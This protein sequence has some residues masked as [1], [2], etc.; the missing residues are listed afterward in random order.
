MNKILL[1]KI[2]IITAAA[3]FYIS[4]LLLATKRRKP[5]LIFGILASALNFG[6][7]GYNFFVN[8]YVPFVSMYQVLTF[9]ALSF[10]L[11]YLYLHFSLKMKWLAPYFT[12][13]SALVLTGV[14]FMPINIVWHF[15]PALQAVWFIPHVFSYMLSYSLCGVAFLLVVINMFWKQK[16]RVDEGV[17]H[18][19]RIAYPFMTTGLLFGAIWANDVWGAFWSW[20]PKENWSLVTWLL[21]SLYLHCRR[22]K[23]LKWLSEVFIII[24][25][26]ALLMTFFGVNLF[27]ASGLHTYT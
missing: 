14:S 7:I 1:L 27:K 19:V 12:A 22:N 4:T 17:Y 5:G 8:G 3:L 25:F 21:Y 2:V 11:T 24:G 9:L 16:E 20:D 18:L 23:S 15:A 10:M 26:I 6:V 13:G